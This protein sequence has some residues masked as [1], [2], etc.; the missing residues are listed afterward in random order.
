MKDDYKKQ[1]NITVN[2]YGQVFVSFWV[3]LDC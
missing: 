1:S 3:P 2:V